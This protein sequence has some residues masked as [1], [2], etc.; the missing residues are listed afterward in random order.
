MAQD[1]PSSSYRTIVYDHLATSSLEAIE[2]LPHIKQSKGRTYLSKWWQAAKKWNLLCDE[3]KEMEDRYLSRSSASFPASSSPSSSYSDSSSSRGGSGSGGS[4]SGSGS[5]SQK[6]IQSQV[7]TAKLEAEARMNAESDR[8]AQVL[9]LLID[10]ESLSESLAST[11]VTKDSPGGAGGSAEGSSVERSSEVFR[12]SKNLEESVL[13]NALEIVL[14]TVPGNV[15]LTIE[16]K[17]AGF[18]KNIASSEFLLGS[19]EESSF[20]GNDSEESSAESKINELIEKAIERVTAADDSTVLLDD[21][22]AAFSESFGL[23][24]GIVRGEGL[25][26]FGGEKKARIADSLGDSQSGL[27]PSP[28]FRETDADGS[29][30]IRDSRESDFYSGNSDSSSKN[31]NS[32]SDKK[33]SDKGSERGS[34]G[35]AE[36]EGERAGDRGSDSNAASWSGSKADRHDKMDENDESRGYDRDNYERGERAYI[37]D[38]S[39]PYEELYD[40]CDTHK[41][42]VICIGDVHG[43]VDEL[44]DLLRLVKYR[45]GDLV[46]L[47]GDLVAKGLCV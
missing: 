16:A 31:Y 26:T 4:G 43:C 41:A 8:I 1:Y 33:R 36:R 19:R 29:R 38:S 24:S 15:P 5:G 23:D 30:E 3:L 27:E 17:G 40:L 12:V 44:K 37:D 47:L 11:S 34:E 7:N 42:R 21:I 13:E 39:V 28:D 32:K 10:T 25:L 45:P 18:L 46:L 2:A 14:R 9:S 20:P 35:R 22:S 6:Q